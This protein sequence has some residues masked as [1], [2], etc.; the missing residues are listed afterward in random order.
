MVNLTKEKKKK[1]YVGEGR[2]GEILKFWA[3]TGDPE[4]ALWVINSCRT[5]T[6]R[7]GDSGAQVEQLI[8]YLLRPED[9]TELY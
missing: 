7:W 1:V 8:S 3:L 4:N 6:S 9:Y 2:V 5:S